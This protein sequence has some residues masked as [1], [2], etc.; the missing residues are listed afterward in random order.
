MSH[1][2]WKQQQGRGRETGRLGDRQTHTDIDRG[3][4]N[5]C[6]LNIEKFWNS[7]I[8]T[9]TLTWLGARRWRWKYFTISAPAWQCVCVCQ[10]VWVCCGWHFIDGRRRHQVATC[11][12]SE[13]AA[14]GGVAL[15]LEDNKRNSNINSKQNNN[16]IQYDKAICACQRP[17]IVS[18]L[19]LK[20]R[21]MSRG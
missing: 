19:G 18:S 7:W 11:R 2:H 17:A 16:N 20:P 5:K 9:C 8:I 14:G 1:R 12:L 10:C 4:D 13:R 6:S 3:T 21:Q 15:G